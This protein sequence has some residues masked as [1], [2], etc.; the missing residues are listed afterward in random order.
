MPPL[1]VVSGQKAIRAFEKC[2]WR[3]AR[4][5]STHISLRKTGNPAV[6]TVPDHK[7]LDAGT[8]R[9]LIRTSGLTVQEFIE[10]LK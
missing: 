8:L 1:P 3:F 7:E 2:D 9:N 5:S 6:L 4:R 10:L